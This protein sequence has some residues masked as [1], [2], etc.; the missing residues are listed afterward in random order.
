MRKVLI[1]L[2]GLTACA[3]P[4]NSVQAP[5]IEISPTFEIDLT[6]TRNSSS[7][8]FKSFPLNDNSFLVFNEY[9]RSIDTVKI[10]GLGGKA[11]KG[12]EIPLE[13]PW[14]IESINY[15][16]PM[17]EG[18][19]F[20][21]QYA[22]YFPT[23][24][25]LEKIEINDTQFGLTFPHSMPLINLT[26]H[27][28]KFL[29]PNTN[30]SIVLLSSRGRSKL[31]RFEKIELAQ[32]DWNNHRLSKLNFKFSSKI[33]ENRIEFQGKGFSISSSVYPQVLIH[34]DK[35]IVSYSYSN[36]IQIYELNSNTS[37]EI[38]PKAIDYKEERT[39]PE[40]NEMIKSRK[41][42][43][44]KSRLW[45]S[46]VTFGPMA[47]LKS[48]SF[49]RLIKKQKKDGKRGDFILE[50]FDKDFNK[51]GESTISEGSKFLTLFY[52]PLGDQLFVKAHEQPNE[53]QLSYHLINLE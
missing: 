11:L 41:E 45:E 51:K 35:V 32:I 37:F 19:A 50:L 34:Q 17:K 31:D 29:D 36:L 2:L 21:D 18:N 25:G 53:D 16:Q 44:E 30:R 13:G 22:I 28:L 38:K 48:G 46:D 47:S 33:D 10:E 23:E 40:I 15:F 9:G 52:I 5:Y 24:E 6:E 14:G 3:E 20:L 4:E 39:K 27:F 49:C 1:L 7:T 12:P 26:N 43:F 42:F 8:I